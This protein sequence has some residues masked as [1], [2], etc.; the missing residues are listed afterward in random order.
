MLTLCLLVLVLGA[1]E[2][3]HLCTMD[4]AAVDA[5]LAKLH[6]ETPPFEQRVEAV[7]IAALAAPYADGPLGEGPDG[8]YDKDPLMDLAHVDCVTYVEQTIAL[9]ASTSYQEAFD[10]LQR[11]RY[12]NGR[13][14]FETRNHFMIADWVA[15]N[16]FCRDAT[17]QLGVPTK[18]VSRTISRKGFFERVKI[19]ELGQDAPDELIELAYIPSAEVESAVE[20]LPSPAVIVFIG[21]I[22]W[23]FALHCGLFVRESPDSA[24]LYHASSKAGKVVAVDLAEYLGG[25]ERYL[26]FTAYAITD[27]TKRDNEPTGGE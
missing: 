25:T 1:D 22:D 18:T 15:N 12:K 20:K 9:A 5:Y 4:T 27:P 16:A 6:A 13:I 10:T 14:A 2:P 24:K 11:I 19:P 7:A 21:K 3:A 26:G 8:K 23:L 17:S